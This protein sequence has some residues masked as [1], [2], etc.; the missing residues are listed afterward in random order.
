MAYAAH[1]TQ[2]RSWKIANGNDH[3]NILQS[4][5]IL[6]NRSRKMLDLKPGSL[7]RPPQLASY[8]D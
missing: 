6:T 1:S 2:Y 7:N 3:G 5:A 4:W 8:N